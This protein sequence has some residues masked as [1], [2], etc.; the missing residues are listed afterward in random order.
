[1]LVAME[2]TKMHAGQYNNLCLI[3]YFQGN[4]IGYTGKC[5]LIHGI[6]GGG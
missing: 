6:V 4:K 1:M 5:A 3:G 2:T